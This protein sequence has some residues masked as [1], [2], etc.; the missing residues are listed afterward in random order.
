M[1]KY[2]DINPKEWKSYDDIETDSLWII[3]RRD[4][5]GLHSNDYYGNFVPQIPYQLL[6]RYTKKG[7]LI[8]DPFIGGGTTAIEALKL[9]RNIVGIDISDEAI[10]NINSKLSSLGKNPGSDYDLLVGNSEN[11]DLKS[12]LEKHKVDNFQFVIFHPPYWDIIHFTE[13][14]EDLSNKS[15]LKEFL[16]S[17]SNVINNT[18]KYL[19]INR[20]CGL[21]IGDKYSKGEIIPLG[22]YCM[23]LFLDKGFTLKGIIV[24]NI[25][26]TKGKA[27]QHSLWRYRALTNDFYQFKHEYIMV[28]KKTKKTKLS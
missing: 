16:D 28:F 17:F 18:T 5:S 13:S 27:N 14:K 26:E 22:F 21:V 25:E 15:Y 12:I 7:D 8:L 1:A 19:E 3:D 4:K 11:Y 9:D 23:N 20:Y 2:N 6:M 24:K 10:N